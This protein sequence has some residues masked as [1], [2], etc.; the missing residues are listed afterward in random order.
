MVARHYMHT[1]KMKERKFIR[2]KVVERIVKMTIE[3]AT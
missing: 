2:S 3:K 1:T